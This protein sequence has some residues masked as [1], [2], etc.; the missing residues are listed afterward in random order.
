MTRRRGSIRAAA[1]RRAQEAKAQ[2]D[3]ERIARE[4]E[5]EAAL[6]DYFEAVGRAAAVRTEARRKAD[7][8][9]ADA[10]VAA[11]APV[12]SSRAAACRLRTLTGSHA[13]VATLCGLSVP[14]VRALLRDPQESTASSGPEP[15][16]PGDPVPNVIDSGSP[17]LSEEP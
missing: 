13:D 2:R 3:A 16:V 5:I 9:L 11:A 17:Q 6:A 7:K 12:K 1:I 10:D 14:A 15:T 4:R 8:L